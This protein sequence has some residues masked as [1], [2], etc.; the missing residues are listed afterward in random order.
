M[1]AVEIDHPA[2]LAHLVLQPANDAVSWIITDETGTELPPVG[3]AIVDVVLKPGRYTARAA[4][5]NDVLTRDFT[6]TAGE[7]QDIVLGN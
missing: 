1:S 5:G 7:S 6:V 2:G 4:I 3:G